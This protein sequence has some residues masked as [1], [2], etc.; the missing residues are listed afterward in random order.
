[1]I[2]KVLVAVDGSEPSGR[3]VSFASELLR[4]RDVEVTVL[5]VVEEP[6][7]VGVWADGLM[8][9]EVIVTPPEIRKELESRAER[10]LE[11]ARS[12]MEGKG[13]KVRTRVRWGN[14]AAEIIDEARTGDHDLVVLGTHGH[15]AL[16]GFLMGSVSDRVARHANCPV[17]LV[18]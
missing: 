18:R 11:E 4:G 15:G 12:A 1:M 8:S 9:P 2:E 17:L 3:A 16:R 7:Y 5:Y 10:V 13:L 6:G 14:P